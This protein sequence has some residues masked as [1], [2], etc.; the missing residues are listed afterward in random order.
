MK[1]KS[2]GLA[3]GGGGL[4]GLA[5]IGVLQVL[6]EN[7]IKPDYISGTS[8]GSLIA[9]LYACGISPYYMEKIA[10]NLSPG[11][12]LD[13]NI[14]GIINYLFSLL[15]PFYKY[16]I[17]GLIKGKRIEKMIYDLTGGK[18]LREI[19]LPLAI[20]ACAID[21]GKKVIFTNQHFES[22][23]EDLLVRD[24]LI[25]EAVRASI[26][27][28]VSFE[29][30]QSQGIRMVDGGLKDIVPAMVNRAMGAEYVLGVNLGKETYQ[31]SVNDIVEIISRTISILTFETSDTEEKIFADMIIFPDTGEVRLDDIEEAPRIIRDG[32]R[33]M[34]EHINRLKKELLAE[35]E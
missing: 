30:A 3:L 28:P 12:Y 17:D 18:K 27:I 19:Q 35:Y 24:A 8:M 22:V 13:Y 16:S 20:I 15:I 14:K 4:R 29:P 31:E 11:N 5:H 23:K 1:R 7:D 32:R 21:S 6:T 34:K 10:V 2:L 25:S 33:R 26:S 9:A